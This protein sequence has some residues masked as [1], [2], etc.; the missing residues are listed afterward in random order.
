MLEISRIFTSFRSPTKNLI[1]IPKWQN[2]QHPFEASSF[3]FTSNIHFFYLSR[4]TNIQSVCE[5]LNCDSS[6]V[7]FNGNQTSAT[8][9]FQLTWQERKSMNHQQ[10]ENSR[11][12]CTWEMPSIFCVSNQRQ[13]SLR[14]HK[15]SIE[16]SYG[17]LFTT[18]GN[19]KPSCAFYSIS[20]S[21]IL[22][23]FFIA[24]NFYFCCCCYSCCLLTIFRIK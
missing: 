22:C 20:L 13:I 10:M 18:S 12:C 14:R 24:H 5:S 17:N 21:S 7:W 23:Q 6:C 11:K 8:T 9:S 19:N 3:F 16:N 15:S 1:L 2:Q 4:H